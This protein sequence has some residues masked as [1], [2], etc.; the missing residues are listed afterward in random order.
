MSPMILVEHEKQKA[1]PML[2]LNCHRGMLVDKI[3]GFVCQLKFAN[4]LSYSKAYV[5]N[6]KTLKVC[7]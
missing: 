6:I 2:R 5:M 7:L 4:F 1:A 3:A